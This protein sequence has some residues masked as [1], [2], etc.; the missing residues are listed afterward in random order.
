[1]LGTGPKIPMGKD[2][3]T[4]NPPK[5]D[6]FQT[7]EEEEEEDDTRPFTREE[8]KNKTLS[9]LQKRGN[10]GGTTLSAKSKLTGSGAGLS[11]KGSLPLRASTVR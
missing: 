4:V 3:V 10:G 2:A 5:L 11:K 6:E 1:M 7:E 8:L 9:L